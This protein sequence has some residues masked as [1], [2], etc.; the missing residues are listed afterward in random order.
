M[1]LS[2]ASIIWR[3]SFPSFLFSVVNSGGFKKTLTAVRK[4]YKTYPNG[5]L[6]YLYS[7]FPYELVG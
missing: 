2:G 5:V 3:W 4:V 6:S 7:Y 1:S